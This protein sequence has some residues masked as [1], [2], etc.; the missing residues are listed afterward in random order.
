MMSRSDPFFRKHEYSEQQRVQMW[1][2][3]EHDLAIC[4]NDGYSAVRFTY[5]YTVLIKL[6][7][8]VLS[9]YGLRVRSVP[10]HHIALLQKCADVMNDQEIVTMGELMR[11]KRN[12][13]LYDCRIEVS[14]SEVDAFVSF[15]NIL[16]GKC[17]K[18]TA[19]GRQ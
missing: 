3:I 8:V 5:S 13:D 7:I 18:H 10:G 2:N 16:H 11:V 6:C 1:K 15:V 9:Y 19:T 17:K 4:I 14:D 12:K